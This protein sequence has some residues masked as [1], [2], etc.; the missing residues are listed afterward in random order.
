M[1]ATRADSSS[2][3]LVRE[4]TSSSASLVEM[5]TTLLEDTLALLMD[6][7]LVTVIYCWLLMMSRWTHIVSPRGV[8]TGIR[9]FSLV[10]RISIDHS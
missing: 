7:L 3:E 6:F 2:H 1:S 8:G 10:V 5:L 9:L 4:A